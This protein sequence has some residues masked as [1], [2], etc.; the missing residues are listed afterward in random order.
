M[1]R[2]YDPTVFAHKLGYLTFCQSLDFWWLHNKRTP[3]ITI[4]RE[5]IMVVL[6]E[7]TCQMVCFI[8]ITIQK[9]F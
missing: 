9:P 7:N 2:R 1:P 5:V 3:S 4:V 6:P 8:K